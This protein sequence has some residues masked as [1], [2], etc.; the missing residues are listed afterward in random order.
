[1][2][3]GIIALVGILGLVAI[4]LAISNGKF[5]TGYTLRATF[6]RAG[7]GFYNGNDVKVRGVSVGT[8][9][10]FHLDADDHVLVT[11]HIRQ[12]I[13]I[14]T[15]ATAS[16]EPLSVFGP[17]YVDL[18]PGAGERSGPFLSPGAAIAHTQP[19]IGLLDVLNNTSGLL[20]SID[21]QDLSTIIDTLGEG[22]D[23][24]GAVIG[25]TLDSTSVIATHSVA[26][27]PQLQT[28]V[29]QLAELAQTFG[30]RG[31]QIAGIAANLNQ[32]LPELTDHS[33]EV[34]ALL[35]DTSSLASDVSQLLEGHQVAINEVVDG[36]GAAVNGLYPDRAGLP[37]LVESLN[38][39]FTF[40]GNILYT[41]GEAIPGNLIAGNIEGY[42]PSD[43]CQLLAGACG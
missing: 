24:T 13:R 12:G 18:E 30:P 5:S 29:S 23:G 36:L 20:N 32:V 27:L 16:I 22:L 35:D 4:I 26:D 25:Q 37:P 11:L 40:I 10:S 3:T 43:A 19:S 42:V 8:V 38:E 1:V 34:S 31:N 41:P 17:T 7:Q 28:L 21:T 33:D 6:D 9:Q 14:P 2:L 39:F 15:T